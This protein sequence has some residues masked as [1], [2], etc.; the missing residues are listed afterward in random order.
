MLDEWDK[1]MDYKMLTNKLPEGP[2][3]GPKA[4]SAPPWAR[5]PTA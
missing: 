5:L 3:A 4:T 1:W 2:P